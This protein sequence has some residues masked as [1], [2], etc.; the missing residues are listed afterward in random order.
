MAILKLV[1][2]PNPLLQMISKPIED[3]TD[4]IK[5]LA[6]NMLE[7]MYN[8]EGIGLA[9]VQVGILKRLIVVDVEWSRSQ[10]KEQS[11][12]YIMIN[13]E[14]I[15]IQDTSQYNEGCLSFPDEFVTIERPKTITVRY[16]SLDG[17]TLELYTDGIL[18]TCIQHEIDHLNGKTISSYISYQKKIM[19]FNRLKKIKSSN[20][21][22]DKEN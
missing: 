3:I 7:T 5:Q 22:S 14:V 6:Y 10:T 19:M 2:A 17:K 4:E 1:I 20:A 16:Q 12:K 18:A 9:A 15:A 21:L 13:P 8:S 11:T